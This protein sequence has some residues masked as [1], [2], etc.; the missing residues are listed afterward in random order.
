MRIHLALVRSIPA[1]GVSRNH[2][3]EFAARSLFD[4][5]KEQS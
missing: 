2:R 4:L 5:A 3:D 1:V